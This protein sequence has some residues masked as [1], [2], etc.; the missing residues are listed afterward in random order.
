MPGLVHGGVFLSSLFLVAKCTAHAR[1]VGL[2][3]DAVVMVMFLSTIPP[4]NSTAFIVD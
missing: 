4:T 1:D 2:A 3:D